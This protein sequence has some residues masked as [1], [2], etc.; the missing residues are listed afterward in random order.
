[1]NWIKEKCESL[2]G[3]FVEFPRVFILIVFYVVAAF[4]VMLAF[5]PVLHSIATFNLMGTTPFYNLIE[6]NYH[7]LKWGFLAVP[8]AILLWG[9]ADAEDLYL[10]LRNRK[11]RF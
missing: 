5:S 6:D 11:Y 7:I 9:W 3:I 8:V 1:M 2:L 4:V 10:K